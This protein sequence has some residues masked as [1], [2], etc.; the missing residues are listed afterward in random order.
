MNYH[1]FQKD[2]QSVFSKKVLI[3]KKILLTLTPPLLLPY[4]SQA[5]ND[6]LIQVGGLNDNKKKVRTFFPYPP[7][8][9]LAIDLNSPPPPSLPVIGTPPTTSSLMA[10][11]SSSMVEDNS[12]KNSSPK[13]TPLLKTL[14]LFPFLFK[15]TTFTKK[16]LFHVC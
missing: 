2:S 4:V 3:V 1:L 11:K 5:P 9:P 7:S 12:T 10:T 6:I 13:P 16:Q 8:P 14:T 15:P